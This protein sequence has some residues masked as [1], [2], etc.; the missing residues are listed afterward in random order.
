MGSEQKL[1]KQRST[2]SD[3]NKHEPQEKHFGMKDVNTTV[4]IVGAVER[5]ATGSALR[6]NTAILRQLQVSVFNSAPN[7]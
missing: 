3:H 4:C 2:A 1:V 7:V 6:S 5:L